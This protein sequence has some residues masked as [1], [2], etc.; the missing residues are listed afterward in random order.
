MG[1]RQTLSETEQ[2]RYEWQLWAPGF[3]PEGQERLRN[4]AVL[5]TRVGGVGGVAAYELV[6]AGVGRLVLAHAGNVRLNDLNRQL[7]MTTD[8]VG[9]PRVECAARRLRELNP[10][11]EIEI[12][13][14][15]VRED[16]VERLVGRVDLVVD[17]APLFRERLLLNRAAVR[18]G[19]PLV[20]CAMYDLEAQITT[21]VPGRTPC[22]ACLYPEEPPGWKRE[23]PVFGAVA[24]VIGSLGAVEAIKVL[25]G[26]GEPLLGR[27]LLCDL[28]DMTFRRAQIKRRADCAVCGSYGERGASAP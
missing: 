6:A 22:L 14:E 3:G 2:A 24:G 25:A 19:K 10:H 17:C 12:V 20:D 18:H 4:A 26:L 7:L 1:P 23:F 16:N 27:L 13:A 15:N 11:I 28:R 21:I 8:A 5:V 9:T